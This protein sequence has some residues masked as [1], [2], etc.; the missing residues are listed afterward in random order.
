MDVAKVPRRTLAELRWLAKSLG[1]RGYSRWTREEL[2]QRTKNVVVYRGDT[3]ITRHLGSDYLRSCAVAEWET[4]G[5]GRYER[6]SVWAWYVPRGMLG[7]LQPISEKEA[8]AIR[9]KRSSAAKAAYQDRY[10]EAIDRIG[11]IPGS[12]LAH[13]VVQGRVDPD[14]AELLA[15][16]ASYR[17][18]HTDYDRLLREGVD[19]DD[20]RDFSRERTI[21]DTW[22]DYL[23]TYDLDSDIARAIAGVLQDPRKC[24][25]RWFKEAEIAVRRAGLPL[26]QLSYPLIREA[27]ETWR[28]SRRMEEDDY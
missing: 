27:I 17:H 5:R 10:S 12:R 14:L 11:A 8:L 7:D 24:H 22:K 2:E 4:E 3:R 6:Y 18:E 23:R 19:R 25:P 28:S 26:D 1:L 21:P 15:F 16:G 20:A 13:A 9:R